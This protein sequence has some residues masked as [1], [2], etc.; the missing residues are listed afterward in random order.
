MS[1][2]PAVARACPEGRARHLWPMN[3]N[4]APTEALTAT[5]PRTD[6]V[7][8]ARTEVLYNADCPVCRF[9]IDAYR[10][11]AQSGDLP[12]RFATLDEAADW[13]LSPDQAARRLHVRQGERL[14]AGL[15]AFRAL[16]AE[17]PGLRWLAWITGLWGLRGVA[18]LIY[19][20]CLAPMLYA[21]H[22][23]R[24][25]RKGKR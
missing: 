11:R 5:P 3:D 17:M 4:P 24:S 16:W 21:L 20:R 7:P 19:E 9:E 15:P 23:R 13:G 18:D 2:Q 1:R 25:A 8:E 10:R 14:L 22:L 12:L 6:R